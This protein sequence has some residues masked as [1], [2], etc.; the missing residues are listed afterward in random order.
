MDTEGPSTVTAR[1]DAMLRATWLAALML[2]VTAG[3]CAGVAG[4]QRP[5]I[6]FLSANS[7]AAMSA[8]TEAFRGGL[9]ELGYVEGESISVEYRYGDGKLDR[10]SAQ[11]AELV[12]LKV[13]AIV[14]EGTTATRFAKA[15][16]STIPIVMAQDP[17]PVGTGFVTSLARPGGNIT[18]L[19]NFRP[20]L[21]GK[22]VELLKEMLPRLA[23]VVAVGTSTTPGNA[24]ALREI[25]GAAKR[26]GLELQYVDVLASKDIDPLV[27]AAGK[28]RADCLLVLAS[29]VLLSSR[30]EVADITAKIGLPAMYYTAEFV[31]DGGLISYGVNSHDLFRRAAGYV[32]K[33]LKGAQPAMLPIEQPTKFE[34]AINLKTAKA[35]GLTIQPSLLQRADQVIE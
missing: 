3:M 10:V 19:S 13:A 29:P 4:Q 2:L 5:R 28:A 1:E 7:A 18:G 32:D 14:T 35:L 26:L 16:T 31:R 12:Q 17:D 27:R 34:L 6:G 21:G 9:R 30:R 33:I 24:Q 23:R 22:R 20:E 15:A 25:E 11:A 8:R